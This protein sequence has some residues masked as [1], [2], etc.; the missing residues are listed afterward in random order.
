[1]LDLKIRIISGAVTNVVQLNFYLK[2]KILNF[3]FLF[4]YRHGLQV[5]QTLTHWRGRPP[6]LSFLHT[7]SPQSRR[8][9]PWLPPCPFGKSWIRHCP[10]EKLIYF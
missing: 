10:V 8:V 6:I 3:L 4:I 5:G 7:N 1:M 2:F 9:G